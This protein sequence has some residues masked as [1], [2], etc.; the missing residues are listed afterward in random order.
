M[1]EMKSFD[2]NGRIIVPMLNGA[3]RDAGEGFIHVSSSMYQLQTRSRIHERTISWRF[4]GIM[5]RVLR[6]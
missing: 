6:L 3:P 1:A 4:L 5:L 2:C